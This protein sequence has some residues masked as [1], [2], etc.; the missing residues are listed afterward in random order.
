MYTIGQISKKSGLP[1]STLRYYDREGLFP[2]IKRN[3]GIRKFGEEEIENIRVIECLK[4]SGWSLKEIK[5]FMAL[6]AQGK[7]TYVQRKRL[8]EEQ[9]RTLE[10]ELRSLEK[11]HAMLEYKC[12]YYEQAILA[13]DEEDVKKILPDKL[14]DEIQALYDFVY[15]S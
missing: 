3:S 10:E 7:E 11:I 12:W 6:R 14:P 8:L 1:I 9:K 15:K 4:R 13:G 2:N 5:R